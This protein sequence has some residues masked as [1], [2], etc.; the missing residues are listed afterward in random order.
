MMSALIDRMLG[1]RDKRRGQSKR[2][3]DEVESP[4]AFR[5]RMLGEQVPDGYAPLR[6]LF[7]TV[8]P[9]VGALAWA[10]A[11][12]LDDAKAV[13]WLAVPATFVIANMFEWRVH[14]NLLHRRWKPAA[15]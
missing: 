9:G 14:K 10:F 7:F 1:P 13:E 8:A 4:E 6:H 15:I 3:D 2:W 5:E 12:G 11:T